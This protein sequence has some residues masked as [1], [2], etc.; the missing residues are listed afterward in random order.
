MPGPSGRRPQLAGRLVTLDCKSYDP[1]VTSL[2]RASH[3]D[4][5]NPPKTSTLG[6]LKLLGFNLSP[7]SNTKLT[8]TRLSLRD[9]PLSSLIAIHLH[10]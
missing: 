10:K 4:H 7:A 9:A 8:G 2:F 1:T 6:V 5:T 3:Y